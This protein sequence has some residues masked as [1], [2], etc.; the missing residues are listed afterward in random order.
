MPG[1]TDSLNNLLSNPMD[2]KYSASALVNDGI[3]DP[4]STLIQ[5]DQKSKLFSPK[6]GLGKMDFLKLLT[7][8]LQYQ[9]PMEPMDNTEFV[10]QLAQFSALE[11]TSNV[12]EAIGNL[13]TSFKESLDI[14]SFSALSMTNASAVSLIG[15]RVRIGESAVKYTGIPG[16]E[17]AIRVHLG[18][19]DS[20]NLRIM[21]EDGNV[22]RTMVATGKDK[23]NSVSLTWDGKNDLL[24]PVKP[25]TYYLFVEGEDK[26]P[27]LYCF[28]EDVIEG[29]RYSAD[30]PLVKISGKELPLGNILDISMV[31]QNGSS[32]PSISTENAIVLI[33]KT[34][35]YTLPELSYTANP[36]QKLNINVDLGGADKVMLEVRDYRGKVVKTLTLDEQAGGVAHTELDCLDY[37]HSEDK[38]YTIH[39]VGNASAYFYGEGKVDGINTAN[40]LVKLRVNGRLVNLS[41]IVD[42]SSKT[43]KV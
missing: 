14:Q 40:G 12:E 18:N 36:N 1:I 31:Q 25:G 39:I 29:V 38:P 30:G 7:T 10:A 21:D 11:G 41:E 33:G 8:Q 4:N 20:A 9:D 34:V 6:E 32:G 26:D 23:Q 19:T 24:E 16:E 42:I 28:I 2:D 15:K 35:R 27:S 17:P 3:L 37:S 22:I 43:T 13:D 5:G